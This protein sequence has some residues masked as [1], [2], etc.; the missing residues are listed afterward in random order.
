M[1]DYFQWNTKI[2]EMTFDGRQPSLDKDNGWTNNF[3]GIQPLMLNNLYWKQPLMED[4][5]Q[6]Q[7]TFDES[8]PL[9]EDE[10]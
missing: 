4:H 6:W 5:P 1:E 7:W 10:L 8:Q 3:N 2:W 9:L